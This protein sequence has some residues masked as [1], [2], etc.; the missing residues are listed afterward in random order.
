MRGAGLGTRADAASLFFP[1]TNSACAFG[2]RVATTC[3]SRTFLGGADAALFTGRETCWS[4][5]YSR[6]GVNGL[7]LLRV[8]LFDAS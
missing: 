4:R 7:E 3:L 1:D 8:Y 2:A 6:T 5:I